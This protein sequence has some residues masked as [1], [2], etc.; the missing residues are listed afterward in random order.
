M[1]VLNLV[2]VTRPTTIQLN[3]H[4]NQQPLIH[5]R[6]LSPQVC[7]EQGGPQ[8]S[9]IAIAPVV[10]FLKDSRECINDRPAIH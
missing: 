3:L 10:G 7:V 5:D 6:L 8:G 2:G 1:A 9:E 4:H